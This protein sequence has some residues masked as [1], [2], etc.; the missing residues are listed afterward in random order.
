MIERRLPPL[1]EWAI[2]ALFSVC[3]LAVLSSAVVAQV[4]IE[5]HL[6]GDRRA[7]DAGAHRV[8]R[9]LANLDP[10]RWQDVQRRQSSASCS[11]GRSA[12]RG[13]TR[14]PVRR[15]ATFHDGRGPRARWTGPR[16]VPS[17]CDWAGLR[18]A[19]IRCTGVQLRRAG[20]N[21]AAPGDV[22]ARVGRDSRPLSS[23]ASRCTLA[24]AVGA[25][26]ESWRTGPLDPATR[27]SLR[28]PPA[29]F[30]LG[31]LEAVP[32]RAD[33][34][35]F[36]RAR[37][38]GW[39]RRVGDERSACAIRRTGQG[40]PLDASAGKRRRRRSPLNRPTALHSRTLA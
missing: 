8:G 37:R 13:P 32:E 19:K 10:H 29:V 7:V 26:Q 3:A 28:V 1:P 36:R 17:C 6:G 39:R 5:K 27:I 15:N 24:A 30:G 40:S 31:L 11:S 9:A 12:G 21:A 14:C 35:A 22:R 33:P 23:P 34:R 4:R 38:R 16:A 25:D 2:V 18:P 20:N